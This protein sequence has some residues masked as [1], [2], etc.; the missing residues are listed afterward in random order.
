[1]ILSCFRWGVTL[2]TTFAGLLVHIEQPRLFARYNF[3]TRGVNAESTIYLSL[4]SVIS[5]EGIKVPLGDSLSQLAR[6]LVLIFYS[7]KALNLKALFV[8]PS[9]SYFPHSDDDISDSCS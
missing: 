5:F 1:M 2:P 7:G 9:K 3:L 8:F 6:L 4:S